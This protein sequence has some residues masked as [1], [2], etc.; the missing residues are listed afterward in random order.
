MGPENVLLEMRGIDKSFPGVKALQNIDFDLFPGEVHCL[1]GENGAGK[2]TLI[3]IISGVYKFDDGR[4]SLNGESI[5]L[6]NPHFA[7]QMG[8]NTVYQELDLVPTLNV[9]ENI[10]LG[11]EITTSLGLLDKKKAEK[12]SKKILQG[13]GITLNVKQRV[14]DLGITYQQLIAIAK[15]LSRKSRIL[16][17]DEPSAALSL[18]QVEMLFDTIRTL[19]HKGIGIIYISHRLEEIF[20]IGDRVTI[21]RDGKLIT[22][23]RVDEL[24]L[25][26]LIRHV[27]GR[28][29][30]DQYIKERLEIGDSVF[31]VKRLSSRGVLKDISF[32]L[33][34]SEML[35]FCGLTGSGRTEVARA[36][37]GIDQKDS[38]EIYI[39]GK[40][41][42]IKSP[43]DAIELGI[44]L[45]PEDRKEQG[46]VLCRPVGEN[47][48][49]PLLRQICHSP[50]GIIKKR[51]LQSLEKQFIARLNIITP[52]SQHLVQYLS[53][54]NQQKVVLAKWLAS[55][56]KILIF[57]EPTRGI[58]VGAKR[59]IYSFM[60]DLVREGVSI[61]MISSELP[62]LLALSDRILIMSEGRIVEEF[63]YQTA[64][65]EKLLERMGQRAAATA[66]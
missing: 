65:Q 5:Q 12:E 49:L 56:C 52:S 35:G 4:I 54:G 34:K 9:A 59:E 63:S 51:E 41:V 39:D 15:A 8:I 31:A 24:D 1:V 27:I 11:Q 47:I 64:T 42:D 37:L 28:S 43:A 58:D 2:S 66:S 46:V 57:D 19:K 45:I 48:S 50:L 3:K 21:L 26:K 29:L 40:K 23:N 53:G 14:Q 20:Q 10:F 44:G 38:G 33:N 32:K 22:T 62:E 60:H 7:Q 36:I 6:H 25:P 55:R 16:I 13:L 61:I 30:Q 17:L 18:E